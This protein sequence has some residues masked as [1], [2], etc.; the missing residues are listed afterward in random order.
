MNDFEEWERLDIDK[1]YFE[2]RMGQ[3]G[4][5]TF[6][7]FLDSEL[8]G[9]YITNDFQEGISIEFGYITPNYWYKEN[10]ELSIS[11]DDIMD[12]SCKIKLIQIITGDERSTVQEEFN[13]RFSEQ[14]KTKTIRI[15]SNFI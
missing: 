3:Y 7:L 9:Q 12:N 2:R 4:A 5:N 1:G 10:V 11:I 14:E 6:R 13:I 15:N 8:L